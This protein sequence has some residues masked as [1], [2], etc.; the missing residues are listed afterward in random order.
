MA[1][2]PEA[3]HAL[4][5]LAALPKSGSTT[6]TKAVLQEMLLSTSGWIFAQ[7]EAHNIKGTDIG[8]GVFEVRLEP[9]Y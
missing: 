7:G 2:S 1:E 6:V 8:A 9:R 4:D 5:Y 3:K